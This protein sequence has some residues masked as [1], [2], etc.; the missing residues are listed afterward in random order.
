M[1]KA[2]NLIG[3]VI[4]YENDE[5]LVS[6]TLENIPEYRYIFI[7]ELIRGGL[8]KD[9]LGLFNISLKEG[10]LVYQPRK[11]KT[12]RSKWNRK[13]IMSIIEESE[14]TFETKDK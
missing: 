14:G 12:E 1:P 2:G 8:K 11:E 3:R 13:K 5:A 9:Y 6:I 7:E 10:N 4:F